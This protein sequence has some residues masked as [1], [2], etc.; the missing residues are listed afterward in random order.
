MKHINFIN[1]I[2]V[3]SNSVLGKTMENDR[4][5]RNTKLKIIKTNERIYKYISGLAM[6][7]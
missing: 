6:I 7:Q 5:H 2:R 1:F 4:K 3:M